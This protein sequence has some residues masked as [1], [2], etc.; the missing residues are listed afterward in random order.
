MGEEANWQIYC[1]AQSA[2]NKAHCQVSLVVDIIKLICHLFS[3]YVSPGISV[4]AEVTA[5]EQFSSL[6][7]PPCVFF[8]FGK[9]RTVRND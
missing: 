3:N 5:G 4:A 6:N 9:I 8:F 1:L 7:P 2:F